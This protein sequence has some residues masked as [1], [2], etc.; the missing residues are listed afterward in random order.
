[1][2]LYVDKELFPVE[3][4]KENTDFIIRDDNLIETKSIQDYYQIDLIKC[5]NLKNMISSKFYFSY[6]DLGGI[7]G[8]ILKYYGITFGSVGLWCNIKKETIKEYTHIDCESFDF[9]K[10]LK[11]DGFF[12]FTFKT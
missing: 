2:N 4:V 11:V 1:M 10:I 5:K 3:N 6:G 8:T 7:L 12:T 9:D